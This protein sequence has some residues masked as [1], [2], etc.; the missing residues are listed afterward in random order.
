MK[1]FF[2]F[3]SSTANAA[4]ENG[5]PS[6]DSRTKHQNTLEAG[7]EGK[8]SSGSCSTSLPSFRSR[9]QKR[10]KEEP[11]NPKQLRRSMSFSSPATNSCLDERC[12]SFSGD[13][14]CSLYDESDTSQHPRDVVPNMWSPERNPVLREYAIKIP[15]EHS[16]MENDSPCSRCP[17]SAGHSPV[18]SPVALRCRPARVSNLLNK[19]EV[20][21]RYID[22]VHED[23]TVN[24]KQKK[25]ASATAMVSNLGRPP[26]PQSIVPSIPKPTKDTTESYLDVDLKDACL[27]QIAQEDTGDTCKITVMC[28]V[29]RNQLTMSDAFEGESATSVEDI[30]EDLKDARPPSVICPSTSP[31]SGEEETDDRLLQRAKE[32]ESR[33]IVPCGGE[34]EFSMLRDKRMS[35][36]DMFQ[37][38]QQLAEDRKQLAHELS[39]QIKARVAERFSAKEQ[40]KQS[41][42]ELDTRT[43][44]LEK[45]K[46]EIQ[47]TLE[48]EMDRRSHDWSVRFS[49]FQSE[50]ERLHERVREL[51]EQNVSFQREV[52]FLEA[53]KAEASTKAASLEMQNSKLNGDL[54]KLRMEHEKLHNSSV[55]LNARFAEVVEE[56]DHIWEYLKDKE[57]ENK[58]LHKVIARLQTI[59]NEQERTITGLRQGCAAELDK[60]S[61]E[62]ASDKTRKLQME[63]I[64][65]TGVEQKLRGE[66]RSCHLEVES[67]R[68]E[69]IALLNRMQG[70]GNGATFCSIRLDQELQARVDS[71]QIQG[72]SLLDKI[73]QLCTKLLDLIKRKKLENESFSGN[74]VLTVSDYTFEYQSIKGGIENLKRSLNTI[75]SVLNEK[76]NVQEQSGEIA[77]GSSPSREQTDDFELKLKEEAML[78]RVLKEAVLSKELDIERLEADLASSLRIQDVLRN[79]IQR[80]QD[81]LS[82]ITH[83]AK[84]LELQVSKKDQVM[85]EIQ[86]DFQESAK[87]LAALRGTLKTVTEE[88]D[89]SWQEAKQLRRSISIMQNE[90]VSL[91]KKIEALDEDIL[92]KEGQITILQDSI[93]KPFD[94]ICSPRS[95]REFDME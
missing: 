36:N 67:L 38:I 55:D 33:F 88:R 80:V 79:E 39:S 61:V 42:K 50:E 47:T 8:P 11:G 77:A 59:C 4:E 40:Y 29:G 69:T 87:E 90:V 92:V 73:S 91:K 60:K 21:D 68:Q 19:N 28:N 15:K 58:A 18:S 71:L 56:R 1:R 32:V 43:R 34:Y 14:P 25:Y 23:A 31:S 30:Y 82:C 10:N 65:L 76:L 53:N 45:E 20:L 54:E 35:S 41:K 85:N 26:R 95:M 22:R 75:N 6:N 49:R 62:C 78:S 64:R 74:D 16:A 7:D 27:P 2:F 51:A 13:V 72:L 24:D 46:N 17:C 83:K 57:G 93:D 63:L 84:Q 94:I 12:F 9:R 81:K 44:R 89:L 52:T 48:R 70:A 86:Q 66:N 3:G 5:T 37:L